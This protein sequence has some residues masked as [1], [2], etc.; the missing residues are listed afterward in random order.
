MK[1]PHEVARV[2]KAAKGH[3]EAQ[4]CH[5]FMARFFIHLTALKTQ[6]VVRL[7]HLLY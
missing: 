1:D 2:Q 7:L 4:W 6:Y 3:Q 5:V